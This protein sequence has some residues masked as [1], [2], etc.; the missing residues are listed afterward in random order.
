MGVLRFFRYLLNKYSKDFFFT[1][2][3]DGKMYINPEFFYID[4]NAIL[5]PCFREVFNPENVSLLRPPPEE[6]VDQK[7]TRAFNLVGQRLDEIIS[8]VNPS[9]SVYIAIDGV[10]GCCKQS[11]QRKRR[12]K[13]AKDRL[14][15]DWDYSNLTA[16]TQ[17]MYDLS[18][19]LK[20]YFRRKNSYTVYINDVRIAGEGEHK[21]I[22]HLESSKDINSACIYSPDADLIMLSL[23]LNKRNITIL[24][25]NVYSDVRGDYIVVRIDK[26]RELIEHDIKFQSITIQYNSRKIIRDV[27]LFLFM[28]GNDF[29]PNVP[30]IDV[31]YDG[32]DELILTYNQIVSQ[33]GYLLT[34]DLQFNMTSL[35][36]LFSIM[37]SQ[38][39]AILLKKY[40]GI[41][42]RAKWP[43][44]LLDSCIKEGKIDF[45]KYR[46]DYYNRNFGEFINES[47]MD[48]V[49]ETVCYEYL[50]GMNFVISYYSKEIPTFDWFYPYHYAPLFVDL[51][52]YV[53]KYTKL[54]FKFNFKPALHLTESLV[55]VLHPKS[56][57]LLPTQVKDHVIAKTAIDMYNYPETF[58]VDLEG[59]IN[60]YEGVVLVPMVPYEKIR[61][62]LR[63]F[64]LENPPALIT[65]ISATEKYIPTP[66]PIFKDYSSPR[67]SRVYKKN[68]ESSQQTNTQ[69]TNNFRPRYVKKVSNYENQ[70][71]VQT[72]IQQNNRP[73][74]RQYRKF[75]NIQEQQP[76]PKQQ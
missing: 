35:T 4:T 32:I 59:K 12:F 39:P 51:Y 54:F 30:A 47:N 45:E 26:L 70:Q 69:Q 66:K 15:T 29:L 49:I 17:L 10:A 6:S 5:H 33:H 2:N 73:I 41:K 1:L 31:A 61:L 21:L 20:I 44:K 48:E 38:E 68:N 37:S 40:D 43:D 71:Q 58:D 52:S 22:R 50:K 23:A 9:K 8:M 60:D 76:Q 63:K 24:R 67:D 36:E 72:Q 42:N 62:L 75:Q 34:D 56:F 13:S 65:I 46:I 28:L 18:D 64:K 14:E 16:G 25:E 55:S 7:L 27:V 74:T 53:Q 19:F 3:K 57:N 11:Q